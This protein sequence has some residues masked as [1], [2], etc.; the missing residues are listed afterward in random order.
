MIELTVDEVVHTLNARIRGR[1]RFLEQFPSIS[2]DSRTL[3][4]GQCFLAIKGPH[5]DGNNFLR[6][7]LEKGA[8]AIIHSR[9]LK[10]LPDCT[11][12]VFLQVEDTTN[13]LQ[14][15]AHY[16]RQKWGGLLLAISGSMGKTTTRHFATKIL[17]QRFRVLQ[18]PGNLNNKIGVPLS[19]LKLRPNHEMA[20]LELGMSG[21]GEIRNLTRICSP[22]HVLLTNV[23]PVHLETLSNLEEIAAAKGEILENLPSS[24]IFFF[25]ADDVRLSHL[26]KNHPGKKISF[27][28]SHRAEV[29]ISG[30]EFE[31][32]QKTHFTLEV[33]GERLNF[34]VPFVGKHLLYDLVAALAIALNF[35]LTH[36]EMLKGIE[37]L[38]I[39][40]MRGQI[41]QIQKPGK[42]C[43]TLWD[44]SYNS[45]PEALRMVLDTFAQLQGFQRKVLAL[46]EML[47]LGPDSVD[48]HQNSGAHVAQCRPNLLITVGA[49]GS[50]ISQGAQKKSL[51]SHQIRHFENSDRAADFLVREL[52]WGDLLL[53]KGSRSV[54]MNHIIE[55]ILQEK[56]PS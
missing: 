45:N 51:S 29:R 4:P 28:L 23:A 12:C 11:N 47:E 27:G 54:K 37:K 49:G 13:A 56:N 38:T 3:E 46:G 32:L 55:K 44:D 18:S 24:G 48:F 33:H 31:Q 35:N 34:T 15:L 43:I 19:L 14:V 20:L 53:V 25:N 17:S 36:G 40:P 5:F 52:T 30:Y 16:V 1:K 9:D 8:S 6:Q 10:T 50:Y 41:L 2:T 26:A 7:A 22:N 39:P 21:S 42:P